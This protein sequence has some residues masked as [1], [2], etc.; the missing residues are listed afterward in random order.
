MGIHMQEIVQNEPQQG[1]PG[2]PDQKIAVASALNAIGVKTNSPGFQAENPHVAR[3]R[4]LLDYRRPTRLVKAL[5]NVS[6][7]VPKK[8]PVSTYDKSVTG[9]KNFIK[10]L[11]DSDEVW[12]VVASGGRS[13]TEQSRG[14]AL[15]RAL[16]APWVRDLQGNAEMTKLRQRTIIEQGRWA[17]EQRLA[18]PYVEPLEHR[19]PMSSARW[20]RS[21]IDPSLASP[22]ARNFGLRSGWSHRRIDRLP[23]DFPPR[24]SVHLP[25]VLQP[26]RTWPAG[27]SRRFLDA[28]APGHDAPAVAPII[29]GRP[30]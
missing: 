2:M 28:F 19:Q 23:S 26:V 25:T 30:R 21:L 29:R 9:I 27:P 20:L 11:P 5:P 13:K 24:K 4:R 15:D 7:P 14:A 18:Q 6:A 1:A 10:S 16:S 22:S 17:R 12:P 3:A 8:G